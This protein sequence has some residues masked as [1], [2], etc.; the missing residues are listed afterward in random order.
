[1]THALRC[2]LTHALRCVCSSGAIRGVCDT[3]V[4]KHWISRFDLWPY[5]EQFT[6]D[7]IPELM[8]ELGGTPDLVIGMC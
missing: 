5:L 4:I 6:S 3:D 2:L 1:M 7:V 8:A